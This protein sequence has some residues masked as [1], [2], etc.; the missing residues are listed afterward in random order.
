M[1]FENKRVLFLFAALFFSITA[2][3]FGQIPS[4]LIDNLHPISPTAWQFLKYTD[5]PV[6][7]YTGI[8][9]ISIP[10]YEIKTD[11]V[12][13][14]LN[15][16]YHSVGNKI[17]QEASWVGL[18]W[19]IQVGSVVQ[20]VNGMDDFNTDNGSNNIKFLPDWPGS[21]VTSQLPYRY[22]YPQ[23]GPTSPGNGWYT[24]Y[25]SSTPNPPQPY[26]SFRIATDYYVPINTNFD[27]RALT[28]FTSPTV[29]SEHDIFKASFLG[30]SINFVV[31][32]NTNQIVVLNNSGYKVI[33]NGDDTW[34]IFVP[35]GE[36]FDFKQKTVVQSNSSFGVFYQNGGSGLQLSS[37]IW[38]LTKIVTKNKKQ[39]S[40]NYSTT[41]VQQE[42]PSY[43]QKLLNVVLNNSQVASMNV[44]YQAYPQS[45]FSPI[46]GNSFG[47]NYS[48]S[49]EA[50]TYLNSITFPQGQINFSTSTRQDITGGMKLDGITISASQLIKSYAFNYSYFDATAVGGNGFTYGDASV[51]SSA[52]NY[53]RLKLLSLTDNAGATHT[54]TYNPTP[55][56]S[57]NSYATDCWGYYNGQLSNT[58]LVPNPS[59]FNITAFGN[60]GDNHSANLSYSQAG[61]LQEIQYP[62]GGKVDFNYELNAFDNYFIPDFSTSANTISHGN[63]LRIQSVTYKQADGTLSKKDVYTY[64]IGKAILP[65][66]MYRNYTASN[67][68]ISG[69]GESETASVNNYNINEFNPSGFFSTSFF[70]SIT[71]VGYD[72]VSHQEV[73]LNNN[74]NGKTVSAFYNNPDIVNNSASSFSQLSATLPALKQ[75]NVPDNGLL[76]SR[77]IYDALN[78]PLKN[79]QNSYNTVS[80][81]IYYGARLFGYTNMFL[82]TMVLGTPQYYFYNQHMIGYY[83]L[84][85]QVTQPAV[86][87][88]TILVETM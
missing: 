10:L 36:E 74:P 22:D 8:A 52:I 75:Y 71:G 76:K 26:Q 34:T 53:Y 35:S 14:P 84:F 41:A 66:T 3:T 60:T 23:T 40:F 54:F 65:V 2:T 57:K 48:R 61:I 11:G 55:L 58:S 37:K 59:Q 62:T 25:P 39:I 7:Q 28:Q 31:D 49:Q 88:Q 72:T 16:T 30:Y 20:I 29:D 38:M 46:M 51:Y 81:N 50:Y 64:S 77:T 43:S 21:P 19:D 13:L 78:N 73:D 68:I 15:L 86:R 45:T 44:N 4:S 1:T 27:I 33:R 24:P 82:Y 5:L 70:G 18:G 9:D 69:S 6:S 87:K 56:P 63:G 79:I 85:D 67:Y 80:S 17:N 83:P 32:W 12:K 47:F 42:Y